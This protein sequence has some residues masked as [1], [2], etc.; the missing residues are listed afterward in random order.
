MADPIA[1]EHD[2]LRKAEELD[3][4]A[5]DPGLID[6]SNASSPKHFVRKNTPTEH[7][8]VGSKQPLA[9]L[10][11][12]VA[13]LALAAVWRWTPLHDWLAP[14]RM[15]S[16]IWRVPS[17][18]MRALVAV[19][20][21]T[22]ASLAMVPITL[23]AV[24]GG[25][26]FEGWDAFVY[27]LTGAIFASAIGFAGGHLLG[28]GAVARLAGSRLGRLT[29]RLADRGIITVAL[30]RLVPIAPF[31]IFNL[32][33]GASHLGFWQFLLG[34][35]LGMAPSICAITVFSSTLFGQ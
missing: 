35:L 28:H 12:I 18:G 20:A 23:L 29:E 31:P 22:L 9:L 5:S 15:S 6:P 24:V 26:L 27:V 13:L 4:I 32:V 8:P 10:A 34:S 17:P 1:I 2:D 3:G 16:F 11:L 30:L 21:V 33:A 7:C 19:A 14:E 25:I